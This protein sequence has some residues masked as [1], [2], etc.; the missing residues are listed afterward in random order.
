MKES[1]KGK[2]DVK[3]DEGIFFG[4]SCKSKAYRC[5]NLS[6]HKVIESAH[7]K[8]D[9]FAERTEEESKRE[10]KD[11]KRFF[12]SEPDTVPVKSENQKPSTPE[13]SVTKLQE[14]STKQVSTEQASIE[15]AFTEQVSTNQASTEQVST[16]QVYT[17]QVST[18]PEQTKPEVEMQEDNNGIHSKGKEPVLAKYVRRH[19]STD[20]IIGDKSEGT[21]TRNKLKGTCLLSDFEPRNVK[22]SLENDSWIEAM[23]EEI[24]K[25]EKN[26]TWTLVPRPKDKNVIK[27]SG[28]SEI[29]WTKMVRYQ[30][31]K[32]D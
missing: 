13:S 5:L 3:G 2:F 7:V 18:K 15:Q 4:Y 12:F 6:T 19:H 16:K 32:P 14:A 23:N 11:Y 1:R 17:E 22:D 27:P 20:Q 30:E 26:K 24:E 8:V 29:S 31:K 9:E 28:Y 21:M 25:I 10:P